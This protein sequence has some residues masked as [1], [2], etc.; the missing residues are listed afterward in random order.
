MQS[1]NNPYNK[2]MLMAG[3]LTIV[4]GII[5]GVITIIINLNKYVNNINRYTE[6][7][8]Y[9]IEAKI[10]EN[11]N[12]YNSYVDEIKSLNEDKLLYQKE[13]ATF[14]KKDY[15][16]KEYKEIEQKITN[17]NAKL[18]E[19]EQLKYS[20][21]T[22]KNK[23]RKEYNEVL[24]VLAEKESAKSLVKCYLVGF[25]IIIVTINAGAY[26]IHLAFRPDADDVILNQQMKINKE[27]EEKLLTLKNMN[28]N[29]ELKNSNTYKDIAE[30]PKKKDNQASGN[31]KIDNST[32]NINNKSTNKKNYHN[33]SKNYN[34]SNGP[35]KNKTNLNN[36]N[37]SNN[38]VKSKT[39]K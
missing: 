9:T 8:K 28:N 10:T 33:N 1:T 4:L 29:K 20:S 14:S 17:I 38:S 18:E 35:R 36:S 30:M 24:E 21:L 25:A 12:N 5:L 15:V 26:F 19:L 39:A 6:E 3:I 22:E 7:N 11:D 16:S 31:S 23:L 32:N 2:T 37:K 34:H 27:Y 13:L